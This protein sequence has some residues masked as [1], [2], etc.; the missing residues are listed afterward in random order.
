MSAL[1][2]KQVWDQ[3]DQSNFRNGRFTATGLCNFW[4]AFDRT[5]KFC[6]TKNFP[7][8][9]EM[10]NMMTNNSMGRTHEYRNNNY[11]WRRPQQQQ[12]FFLPNPKK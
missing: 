6:D 5:I 12:R 11:T 7:S 2:F 1:E 4:R 8:V 3:E 10:K 9:E